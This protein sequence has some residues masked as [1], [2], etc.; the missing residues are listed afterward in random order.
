LTLALALAASS[1]LP[2][3]VARSADEGMPQAVAVT[4]AFSDGDYGALIAEFDRPGEPPELRYADGLWA[5]DGE[6]L[7]QLSP[8]PRLDS[9]AP[10]YDLTVTEHLTG[11]RHVLPLGRAHEDLKVRAVAHTAIAM[12]PSA[13]PQW[14]RLSDG[15][16]VALNHE[17][18]MHRAGPGRGFALIQDG[19]SLSLGLPHRDD[20]LPLFREIEEVVCAT[21]LTNTHDTAWDATSDHYKVVQLVPA[22]GGPARVDGDLGEWSGDDALAV[23][24]L[25]SVLSGG[26]GWD[27]PRDGSFGVA[28]R[29]HHGRLTVA[30]RVRD[31]DLILGQDRLEFDVGSDVHVLPLRSAGPVDQGNWSGLEA[32]FTNAV[33]FGTGV[34]ASFDVGGHAPRRDALPLVV[35][36]LDADSGQEPTVLASAP[37]LRSLALNT[38]ETFE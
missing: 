9:D 7:L 13:A 29:L 20:S 38:H 26:G 34:E 37:S 33:D 16:Q 2:G 25:G 10:L 19:N 23:D 27:G 18:D 28:A 12:G 8:A 22:S 5:F 14:L 4:V 24:T 35:R 15:R 11:G 31:D 32:V 30:V 3:C 21:W 36:Y 1:I 6:R 17:F